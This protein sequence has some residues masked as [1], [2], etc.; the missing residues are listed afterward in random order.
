MEMRK[1]LFNGNH[2]DIASSLENIGLCY[3]SL[4]QFENAID[5]L[6]ESLE[7]KK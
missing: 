5:Y 7:M 6:L 1:K 3:N 2:P 4:N